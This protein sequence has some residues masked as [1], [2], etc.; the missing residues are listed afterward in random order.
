[1]ED[2]RLYRGFLVF[3]FMTICLTMFWI[4]KV[5]AKS[6]IDDRPEVFKRIEGPRTFHLFAISTKEKD[7][8][9]QKIPILTLIVDK[10]GKG[11][12]IPTNRSNLE[13]LS[14]EEAEK[15]WGKASNRHTVYTYV[16]SFTTEDL[17][18]CRLIFMV[19]QRK[20]LTVWQANVDGIGWVHPTKL[21]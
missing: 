15:M 14:L 1:M 9:L 5:A 19:N 4:P 11:E 2:I 18:R 7:S 20:Y 3:M 6:V 13:N 10:K 17:K 21:K 8:T 12:L 16:F